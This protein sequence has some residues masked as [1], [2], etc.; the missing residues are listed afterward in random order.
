LRGRTPGPARLHVAV[1]VSAVLACATGGPPLSAQGAPSARLG[2]TVTDSVHG[3][4]LAHATVMAVQLSA[5]SRALISVYTDDRGRF[6]FDSLVAGRYTVSFAAPMLDSLDLVMPEHQLDLAAGE[7]STLDLSTPS[8]VTLRAA[9]CPGLHLGAGR[10]AII[11]EVTDAAT[12]RPLA[13]ATVAVA[14]KDL[15]LDKGTLHAESIARAGAVT[16]D[17]AGVYR[18]CGVP[19]DNLLALQ[20]Q[21]GAASG[22]AVDAV[23]DDSTGV[24]RRNL[25]FSVD[26]VR[27]AR[28]SMPSG[29]PDAVRQPDS[30]G[31]ATVRGMVHG[32]GG[33]L[34]NVQVQLANSHRLARSDS[35]GRFVLAGLPAGT[36]MLEARRIG[37]ALVRVSVELRSE[38]TVTQDLH[39]E[40]IVSLDSIRIVAQRLRY[41]E[42]ERHRKGGWGRYMDEADILRRNP[43]QTIDLL[44]TSPGMRV[45]YVDGQPTLVSSRGA[46]S[47]RRRECAINVVIDGM[48]HMDIDMVHPADIAAIETY[49]SSIGVPPEFSMSSPCGAVVIWTKR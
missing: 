33:A 31:T 35:L 12:D 3:R 11:G 37:Y 17:S 36:Q 23:V 13:G 22:A 47:L 25:S 27:T 10:G 4:P 28:G 40:R 39:F 30:V 24:L 38:R 34:A 18:L 2:G 49:T 45:G 20:V 41:P 14:W 43:I 42:F 29:G 48:Q 32:P 26:S 7:R 46:I 9:A 44:R 8:G 6:Q 19:T 21:R 16:T 1:L 5:G 15:V